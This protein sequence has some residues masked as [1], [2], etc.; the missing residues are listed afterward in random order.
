MS[1]PD[2][3]LTKHTLLVQRSPQALIHYH[4]MVSPHFTHQ[5]KHAR[6][7]E[8]ERKRERE[9]EKRQGGERQTET[10][11]ERLSLVYMKLFLV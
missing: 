11:R 5:T 8:R 9:R 3:N 6:E 7:R 2:K 1:V 10:D 4:T